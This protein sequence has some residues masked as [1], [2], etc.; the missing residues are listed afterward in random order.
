MPAWLT[1]RSGRAWVRSQGRLYYGTE[2]IEGRL[3]QPSEQ[4]YVRLGQAVA[5]LHTACQD[6]LPASKSYTSMRIEEYRTQERLFRKRFKEVRRRSGAGVWFRGH[7]DECMAL[8]REAWQLLASPEV[9]HILDEEKRH[10]VLVHGDITIPNVMLTDSRLTFID[11]DGLAPGSMYVEIAR[12]ASN[13]AYFNP[14]LISAFLRG[15]EEVRPLNAGERRLVSGLFRLPREAWSTAFQ[16]TKGRGRRKLRQ[17]DTGWEARLNAVRWMDQWAVE[18][19]PFI[20][21]TPPAAPVM[22]AAELPAEPAPPEG[23]GVLP[24]GEI[25]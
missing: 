1:T 9:K 15:Y 17:L 4:D 16:V 13:T 21:P 6:S 10:P 3:L 2:W 19:P 5:S 12:T 25:T 11:W 20:A 14:D 24:S 23:A 22:E 8:A 18:Q 7:G